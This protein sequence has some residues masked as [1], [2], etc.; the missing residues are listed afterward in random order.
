VRGSVAAV[1]QAFNVTIQRYRNGTQS[2]RANT[3]DPRIDDPAGALIMA[4]G[5][6]ES[7]GY[8]HPLDQQI[9]MTAPR[10]GPQSSLVGVAPL[11]KPAYTSACFKKSKSETI[12]TLGG[13]P[14]ATYTGNSYAG[15]YDTDIA[16]CGYTPP[17]I[18]AAYNLTALYA[19]GYNGAGQT[20]VIIDWCG[21]PTIQSDANAFSAKFGLP[22]LT[23]NNFSIT[24]YPAPSTCSSEDPEINIDVEWSHAI[25]P[26]ANIALVVPPTADFDDVD[27]A[28]LY[29]V[30]NGLGNVIS[31]S[32]GSEE[33]YT[34]TSII[35]T[36]NNII[37]SAS[38][39]G[40]SAN[41][42]SGDSGDYTYGYPQY[43]PASVITPADSPY[44]TAIGGISLGLTKTDGIS[45]QAGWGTNETLLASEG[46]IY[47]PPINFGF[48]FGAGGGPSA[49][50]S[51]PSWQ[52]G[53]KGKFRQVPDISWLADPFTGA[54]IALSEPGV[55]PSPVY[56]VYGGT[57]LATPMFSGLWAIADEE[58]GASLGQAAPTLYTMP[59]STILDVTPYGSKTNV[60]ATI[61]AAPGEVSSYTAEDLAQPLENSRRFYSVVWN[62]PLEQDTAYVL[63]FGTDSSLATK[64]GWDNVTGLGVPNGQAFADYFHPSAP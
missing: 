61:T 51:K 21:S 31:N 29:A 6:L 36:Q 20:I 38:V 44:A 28:L 11:S 34:P 2:F 12:S 10:T 59:S 55:S 30:E 33:Y 52:T 7:T 4:V 13:D 43:N 39:L 57:S 18:Q 56:T 50:F 63:T 22:L 23:S 47:D 5:G 41:F 16:G 60:K 14:S 54:V 27:S 1:Q 3:A 53:V 24:N 19:E 48:G 58:Y 8:T 46:Y 42:A 35:D 15:T 49:I 40:I 32:Y 26:G 45:F 25:A 62:Y 37:E 64:P 17:E 9:L